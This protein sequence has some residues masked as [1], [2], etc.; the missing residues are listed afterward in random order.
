MTNPTYE[1]ITY[2]NTPLQDVEITHS[3][4]EMVNVPFAEAITRGVD[5]ADKEKG[6][7]S[8][9]VPENKDVNTEAYNIQSSKDVISA[10]QLESKEKL[11]EVKPREA[12]F[13]KQ[14]IVQK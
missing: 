11:E 14:E 5:N 2:T 10:Y 3:T 1:E 6:E 8:I 7:V 13:K 12:I 4:N 9:N